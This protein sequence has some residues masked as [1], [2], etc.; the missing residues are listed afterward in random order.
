M[1]RSA[2]RRAR[3][4]G[5]LLLGVMTVFYVVYNFLHE[6][7]PTSVPSP[8]SID[9]L[10]P[11]SFRDSRTLAHTYV[12]EQVNT[13]P[14]LHPPRSE[15]GKYL[16]FLPHSG[17]HNQRIALEN[18]AVLARVLNR[19]L[20]VPPV[21]LGKVP[22]WAE[23]EA[24]RTILENSDK[25]GL[26]RCAAGRGD[27][28]LPAECVD[29][30]EYTQVGWDWLVDLE[31]VTS[32]RGWVDRW[33]FSLDY[34][35]RS[36]ETGGLGLDPAQ[37][38]TMEETRRFHYR[39]YDEAE[40][41]TPLN[42]FSHR[43]NLETLHELSDYRLLHLGS[44]SGT[45]RLRLTTPENQEIRRQ[46]LS[47]MQITN[48]IVVPLAEKIAKLLGGEDDVGYISLHARITEELFRRE[49]GRNI[50]DA[51]WSLAR[52]LGVEEGVIESME[53]GVWARSLGWRFEV[54]RK[55]EN[56]LADDEE[57]AAEHGL[58]PYPSP[59]ARDSYSSAPISSSWT[60]TRPSQLTCPRLPHT[61][62]PKTPFNAPLFLASDS[63]D[64]SVHPALR[65]IY[66]TFPCIFTLDSDEIKEIVDTELG[67]LVNESD[68]AG[69]QD[70]L[71]PFLDAE[72][73][74]RGK[75][76]SGTRGSTSSRFVVDVE[77]NLV[78][79]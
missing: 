61:T 67:D 35:S 53:R 64:P 37:V 50:R 71:R 6:P 30:F 63:R 58:E 72:L 4:H 75:I 59:P 31:K 27:V 10:L 26:R 16:A 34:I 74:A 23:F 22:P 79:G 69:L 21:W 66:S 73:A 5:P 11:R 17:Y 54:L 18:A 62:K 29:Y 44:L 41:E 49:A 8:I 45:T 9:P 70:L 68:G 40:D 38:Y 78:K 46:V 42:M 60:R 28:Q 76:V 51:F 52:R 32:E 20:I 13:H 57:R 2:I 33:D 48:P 56:D 24:L 15:D 43:M 36:L 14:T 47:S 55:R 25:S 19:T 65:I 77:S 7:R 3:R 1:A 39:Y 12:A